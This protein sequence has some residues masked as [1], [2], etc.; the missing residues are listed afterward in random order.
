MMATTCTRGTDLLPVHVHA[1]LHLTWR[2][3]QL[4]KKQARDPALLFLACV[5]LRTGKRAHSVLRKCWKALP[6]I[7]HVPGAGGMK[8]DEPGCRKKPVRVQS[9]MQ[10][11]FLSPPLVGNF[12]SLAGLWLASPGGAWTRALLGSCGWF[13]HQL[14]LPKQ[15]ELVNWSN[16]LAIQAQIPPH[17]RQ[18]RIIWSFCQIRLTEYILNADWKVKLKGCCTYFLGTQ[19]Q[20]SHGLTLNCEHMCIC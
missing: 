2:E 13:Y 14:C 3:N 4:L 16:Y 10:T 17:E 1:Q 9:R 20:A 6:S 8:Y 19:Y 5:I 15:N 18:R 11:L 12:P 7:T